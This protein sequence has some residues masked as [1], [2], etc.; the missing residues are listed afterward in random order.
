MITKDMQQLIDQFTPTVAIRLK[1]KKIRRSTTDASRKAARRR[2][3][4]SR[5]INRK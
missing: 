3:K 4:R 5:K 2:V 1:G